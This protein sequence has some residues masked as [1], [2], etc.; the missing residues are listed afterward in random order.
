MKRPHNPT[1]IGDHLF[2]PPFFNPAPSFGIQFQAIGEGGPSGDLSIKQST[3]IARPGMRTMTL[4]LSVP[5]GPSCFNFGIYPVP[6]E[7]PPKGRP[8]NPYNN[9][10]YTAPDFTRIVGLSKS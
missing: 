4:S 7:N 5:I 8:V 9:F 3:P 1:A 6:G 2:I 10:V